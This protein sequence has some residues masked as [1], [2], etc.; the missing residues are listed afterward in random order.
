MYEQ[1]LFLLRNLICNINTYRQ[2]QIDKMLTKY[3]FL[4]GR[5]M[6]FWMAYWKK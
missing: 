4:L 1:H 3:K 5:I 2:I 6:Q